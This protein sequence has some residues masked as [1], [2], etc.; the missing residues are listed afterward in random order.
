MVLFLGHMRHLHLGNNTSAHNQNCLVN[1]KILIEIY[2]IYILLDTTRFCKCHS[3]ANSLISIN[4]KHYN[5]VIMSAIA[6]QITG[7]AIVC[8]TVGSGPDQRKHQSSAL[9][10]FV[11]GIH[12]GPVNSPHKR[13]VTRKRL[14]FDGVIMKP[15]IGTQNQRGDWKFILKR[16]LKL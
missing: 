7:V 12:R 1:H 4:A 14:P 16:K 11:Q 6:C 2:S 8:S 15:T 13:P 5:D 9:L 3:V 10:A